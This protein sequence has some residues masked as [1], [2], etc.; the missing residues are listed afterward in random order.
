MTSRCAWLR[1]GATKFAATAIVLPLAGTLW[2]SA[3]MIARRALPFLALPAFAQNVPARPVRVIVPFPPGGTT[4]VLARAIGAKWQEA[5]GQQVVIDNRGGGGGVI[6][7]EAAFRA[8]PDGHTLV[9]GNNQTHATNAA[10]IANLP[11]DAAGFA[12]ITLV[13]RVPHALVVPAASPVRSV[14]A[15]V[16]R[17]RRQPTSY[18][19]PSAGSTA[20]I[21]AETFSR[22]NG[23]N[24]TH[25][26]YRGAAPAVQDLVAGV[27]DFMMASWASVATLVADG[28]L[29][30]LGVGGDARFADAPDVPTLSEQGFAYLSA[31]AWFGYFAPAGTAEPIVARV[32]A[33]TEAA[34]TDAT[35]RP[36]LEAAGF[37]LATMPPAQ[38][39]RFHREEIARWAALVRESGVTVSD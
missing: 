22:R 3:R 2:H 30:A 26:P 24:A 29:R 15:L 18:A 9:L 14:A 27:V 12:A 13:A 17:G 23:L 33:A 34:L 16:E 25:V 11:Y 38:F 20:H 35:I 7:T 6:G 32:H 37:R 10:L 21:V 5:W 39:A 1:A 28:R 19:S 36:R 8:A 31:D 4:D